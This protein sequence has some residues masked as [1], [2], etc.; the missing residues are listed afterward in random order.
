MRHWRSALRLSA[1][2][3]LALLIT[4]AAQAQIYS[5][6]FERADGP[7]GDWTVS[8]GT[9]NIVDGELIGGPAAGGDQECFAGD[10]AIVMPDN[11]RLSFDIR[12]NSPAG[13]GVGRHGGIMFNMQGV[14]P[15]STQ[16]GYLVWWIDRVIDRGFNLTRRDNGGFNHLVVGDGAGVAPDDPPS[17]WTIEVVGSTIRV[18]GDDVLYIEHV[19]NTYR[20]GRIAAWTWDGKGQEVAFDNVVVEDPPAGCEPCFEVSSEGPD[21]SGTP[22]TFDAGCTFGDVTTF[23]WDF[24]DGSGGEGE[25]IDHTYAEGGTYSVLLTVSGPGCDEFVSR[26]IVVRE[27]VPYDCQGVVASDDFEDDAID[28][29]NVQGGTWAESGGVMTAGPSAAGGAGA[30]QQLY[31]GDPSTSLPADQVVIEFDWNFLSAGNV[32]GVGKHA[33]VYFCW[34]GGGNRWGAGSRGYQ[35]WWIDRASDHGFVLAVWNPGLGTILN[36]TTGDLFAEPPRNVRIEIDGEHIRVYGDDILAFDVVDTTFRGGQ[37]AFW[38]WEQGQHVDFDNV[39][40]DGPQLAPCFEIVKNAP[41]VVDG[42]ITFDGDCTSVADDVDDLPQLSWDYGDGNGDD[43]N[44]VRHTY[45]EPGTYTVT[46]TAEI[47]GEVQNFTR[48]VT[49]S[50]LATE[51]EDG[52]DAPG[53]D[54][55]P[56]TVATGEWTRVDGALTTGPTAAEHWIWAG[57]PPEVAPGNTTFEFDYEFVAPGTVPAVGRHGGFAF[58]C[59]APSTRAGFS[60]YFFDWIDRDG[61]RGVRFT[62]SDGGPDTILV[63]GQGLAD[64]PADPPIHYR[65]EIDGPNIRIFGD[66]VL[67]VDVVDDTYRGG[68]FGFWTW[69][70]GQEVAI[71]NFEQVESSLLNPCFECRPG[72][73]LAVDQT[74]TF[75][76]SCAEVFCDVGSILSYSWDFGDDGDPASGVEVAHAYSTAG[77]YTVT[78]SVEDSNGEEASV[79]KDVTIFEEKLPFADCFARPVG[80]L[81]GWTVPLG[82]WSILGNETAGTATTTGAPDAESWAWCGEPAGATGEPNIVIQFDVANVF[83]TGSPLDSVKRHFGIMFYSSAVTTNRTAPDSSGYGLWWIDRAGDRGLSL[84]RLDGATR[85]SLATGAGSKR[86]DPPSVWRIEVDGTVI[87]VFGDDLLLIEVEDETYRTGYLGFWAWKNM[88]VGIDNVQVGRLGDPLPECAPVGGLQRACD[89]NQD[90]NFDISDAVALLNFLFAGGAPPPCGEGGISDAGN[91]ALLDANGDGNLDISD[92]AYK[93]SY[94]FTGGPEPATG[95]QGD[96]LLILDCPDTACAQGDD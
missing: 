1:S 24:G 82:D 10:P 85:T 39:C 20:G 6:D 93:L 23:T 90:G 63:N 79:S 4:N 50:P 34:Q 27:G 11:Y 19:D 41:P 22:L 47:P 55:G 84:T 48:D 21:L 46:L 91:V 12:W 52:F 64:A 53:V 96:C 75:D 9:W 42:A 30:E 88:S 2:I 8:N 37:L 31:L 54:L 40:I 38:T 7:V 15:R 60:G 81:D 3:V 66:D 49:V 33:G 35:L 45:T 78:L 51:F 56:W 43:G 69:A 92:A 17:R 95:G 29:W 14:G 67:F 59:D 73:L 74:G 57:N 62:R 71:D 68:F 72:A 83:F 58:C 36:P 26:E 25:T 44:I 76:A 28:G 80:P 87:R 89:F 13:G 16:S 32:A 77:T 86:D 61:D 94:L 70:G 5:D 18:F 65:V